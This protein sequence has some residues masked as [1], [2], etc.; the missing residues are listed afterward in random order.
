MASTL[1]RK[2]RYVRKP[3]Y[4]PRYVR[5]TYR[6]PVTPRR[7]L[8][9]A[10]PPA[11]KPEDLLVATYLPL[12]K[13]QE[14]KDPVT[15]SKTEYSVLCGPRMRLLK[16]PSLE[17][18][19]SSIRALFAGSTGSASKIYRFNVG[20]VLTISTSAAGVVNSVINNSVLVSNPDFVALSS[21]F[22]EYFIYSMNAKFEPASRYQYIPATVSLPTT[23]YANQAVGLCSLYHGQSPYSSMALM[24]SSGSFKYT[25]T[26]QPFQMHWM[27]NER[28]KDGVVA[29]ETA[30]T[31]SWN[32]VNNASQYQGTIQIISGSGENMAVSKEFGQFAVVWKILFRVRL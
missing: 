16:D 3:A 11:P 13:H 28:Y 32:P 20:T 9:S 5:K 6:K 25:S 4:K 26:A 1:T 8:R 10:G 24:A 19:R 23:V 14:D 21:I 27:N 12:C 29:T 15:E 7:V 2:P 22:N 30:P 17:P 18:L 31:Q